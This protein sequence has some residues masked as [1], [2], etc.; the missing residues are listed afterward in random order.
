M[1]PLILRSLYA[2]GP[3]HHRRQHPHLYQRYKYTSMK[4]YLLII[5]QDM[6]AEQIVN[7][8]TSR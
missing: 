6:F 3:H 4:P 5:L 1:G 2:T 8:C 7:T